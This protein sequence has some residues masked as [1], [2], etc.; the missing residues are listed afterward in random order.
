MAIAEQ[1]WEPE[2]PFTELEEGEHLLPEPETSFGEEEIARPLAMKAGGLP[3]ATRGLGRVY[4]KI[5]ARKQGDLPGD[6][7]SR[8]HEG[9]LVGTGFDYELTLPRDAATGQATGKRRHSPVT[10]ALPWGA[11][12]PLLFTAAT[13]NEQLPKIVFEFPA[14][15]QDGSE[16]V[17]QRVTL[18]DALV[19]GYHH[20][21]DVKGEPT[22]IDRIS[23][24]FGQIT[25]EDLGAKTIA[26]DDWVATENEA[27]EAESWEAETY[28]I[29]GAGVRRSE[30]GGFA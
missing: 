20:S 6:S 5:T 15:N 18:T 1:R 8:G 12:S 3:A 17:A 23:F 30:A 26:R 13:T 14:V 22:E 28:E 29:D 19:S 4:V 11:A 10:L 25:I 24:T 21:A 9:W 27:V 16:F 7:R 2:S